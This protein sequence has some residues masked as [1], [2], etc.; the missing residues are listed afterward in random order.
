MAK[1]KNNKLQQYELDISKEKEKIEEKIKVLEKRI[2]S[3]S[4]K[5]EIINDI[6]NKLNIELQNVDPKAFKLI[7][8]LRTSL[9]KNFEALNL[10]TDM[11]LKTED[12]IFKYRKMLVDIENQKVNN[13]IKLLKETSDTENDVTKI[14]M[15]INQ[16]FNEIK[17]TDNPLVHEAL[18]E[19]EEQGY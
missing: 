16:Q 9:N 14:L 5:E 18:K 15:Q 3:Y 11:I 8:Q 12:L 17:N 2:L 7:S 4:L 1:E 6:I 13:Y 19:L 10:I